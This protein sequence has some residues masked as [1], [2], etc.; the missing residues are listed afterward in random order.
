M[1]LIN[2]QQTRKANKNILIPWFGEILAEGLH[3][4]V[5]TEQSLGKTV[6]YYR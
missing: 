1:V 4:T 3:R 6:N 2:C 5:S